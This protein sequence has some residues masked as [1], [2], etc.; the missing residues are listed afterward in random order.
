[1]ADSDKAA[2]QTK[3]PGSLRTA[4]DLNDKLDSLKRGRQLLEA[5]WKLNL[6]FYKG[7]QYTYYNKALRRLETLPVED[8]EKPR[9]RVRIVNNQIAPGAHALL[10]KLTKTKPVTH[11]IPA[12]GSNADVKAAQLADKLLEHWWKEFSLDD[13]LAEA[14]LWSIITGQGY[15]KI[16][17]DPNAG[18]QMRFLLD[19]N[20][21]PITDSALQDLFR[22]ELANAGVQPQEQVVYMGDI[23]VEVLSPFNVYCDDSAQVFEDAKYVICIHYMTPEEIKKKWG[24]DVKPDSLPSGLDLAPTLPGSSVNSTEPSVKGV[25]VGYFLPQPTLP[26]GRVVVWVDEHILEDHPWP[27]PFDKLPLVKFPGIRV[28]GQLYDMGDVEIAIPIQKDLNKTIS[29]IVEYK[30]LTLKPRVWAP[31]G[32]LTGVRL[33]SEPGAVYEY[34]IIGDHRPEIEQLPAIPP[35]VFEHLKNLRDDIRQAFSIVDITEGTPPPNV[36]AGIAIDLLQEM[37]TDRLAPR[38]ILLERVLARSGEL[39]L[40]LAQAYYKEPRLLKIYGS[41]GSAKAKRFTQADLQ[42]GVSIHVETGSALPRTRAGRQQRILDY[43]DRGVLRPDQAYKYLDIADLEGLSTLFQA[44]E[45]QA[46][47]EHDKLIAGEP[48]NVVAMMNAQMQIQNG[49]AVGPEGEPVTDPEAAQQYIEQE[50]LRPHPFENLQTH[51]DV[52]SLFMKSTEFESLPMEVKQRFLTHFSL[53]QEALAQLPKPIEFKAVTPT[54][55]IKS[56]AGP[57]AISKILDR[58]GIDVTPEEMQE[59]PLETWVTDSLDKIDQDEAGN[60]PL[61]PLDMQLKAMEIQTKLADA[62]IRSGTI[63]QQNQMKAEQHFQQLGSQAG[64]QVHKEREAKAKADLAE[65]K[66]RESSF[67]PKPTPRGK[68]NGKA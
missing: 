24:V 13:K 46:Y 67:K 8:G 31:T 48:I 32:S 9:Y 15:W 65:K 20:G 17:W 34:N 61:T 62:A 36:E 18:K 52:H 38:V 25:N 50:S 7:K 35:Y 49:E 45:D 19:P 4:S 54:L 1:M 30:N 66:L 33:T 23:K 44:D 16:T 63:A 55:Q 10:A 51:L 3:D 42:G 11:A 37:A 60:D 56:T 28:P 26:N 68:S 39:M 22:A 59:P 57:T 27:Y 12:S 29:Q 40:S 43:V 41:G 5:Q 64:I 14:L 6:A 53:T 47:R 2:G 58:A 21:Q